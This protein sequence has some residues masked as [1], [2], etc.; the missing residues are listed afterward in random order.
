[1]K[2]GAILANSGHFNV[3]INVKQLHEYESHQARDNIE[4]FDVNGKTLDLL[5]EGR[6]VNLAAADGHA[7]EIMDMSFSI[8]LLSVIHIAQ[9]FSSNTQKTLFSV[10]PYIDQKV[11]EIALQAQGIEIDKLTEAQKSYLENGF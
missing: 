6:L 7:A 11:A 8:Q 10:P 5:A 3:E 1:M 9:N 2:D 4:S